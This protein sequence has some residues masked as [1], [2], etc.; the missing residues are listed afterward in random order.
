MSDTAIRLGVDT[1][2][3]GLSAAFV[4]PAIFMIDRS[5]MEATSGKAKSIA[6][7]LRGSMTSL[8]SRPIAFITSVPCLLLYSVYFATYTTA[9][10]YDTL[11]TLDS[12]ETAWSQQT[13]SMGKFLS[14]TAVNLSVC[15]FKDMKFTKLY[16]VGAPRQMPISSLM[17]FA[18]RDSLTIFASFNIP[19]LLAPV[20]GLNLAQILTPCTMQFLSTPLHLLGLDL[21][22]RKHQTIKSRIDT[23]GANYWRSSFARI[24]RILPAFGIAGV[25]N[26]EI[27]TNSTDYIQ[28]KL[29]K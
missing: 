19:P 9:N 26:R 25:L 15:V 2:S 5:I 17:L 10:M 14:T 23:V 20:L 6:H 29:H 4:A 16:G 28:R 12:P 27:R 11:S 21:Y 3:A 7:S 22:N 24:C 8:A 13:T 18:G 1:L